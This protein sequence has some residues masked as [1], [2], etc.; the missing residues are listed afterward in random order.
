[1]K[2]LT[3]AEYDVPEGSRLLRFA[4]HVRNFRALY[5]IAGGGW[6]VPP[7]HR[8]AHPG[9]PAMAS[10]YNGRPAAAQSQSP[11]AAPAAPADSGSTQSSASPA[12]ASPSPVDTGTLASSAPAATVA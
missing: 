7:P 6:V 10:R 11:A 4:T 1:M 8:G 3:A 2:M 5:A 9:H 12:E